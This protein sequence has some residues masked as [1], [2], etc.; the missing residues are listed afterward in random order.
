MDYKTRKALDLCLGEEY[1]S[2][3]LAKTT[4]GFVCSE[5]P[6]SLSTSIGL[7]IRHA[8]VLAGWR[9][10]QHKTQQLRVDVVWLEKAT[11]SLVIGNDQREVDETTEG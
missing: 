11:T 5:N 3:G 9:V 4:A 10:L 2:L 7:S 1:L 8:S 6:N